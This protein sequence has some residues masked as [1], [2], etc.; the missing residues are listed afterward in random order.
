MGEEE[1]VISCEGFLFALFAAI[2]FFAVSFRNFISVSLFCS[3][4][5]CL[6]FTGSGIVLF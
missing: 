2:L 4:V 1:V 6:I 5:W 3:F